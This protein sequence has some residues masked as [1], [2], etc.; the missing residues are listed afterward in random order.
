MDLT[1]FNNVLY[2][3]S[4]F[5]T[6]GAK[7]HAIA[8]KIT[9]KQTALVDCRNSLFLGQGAVRMI[10]IPL[11]DD[12]F[13]I[14]NAIKIG[15]NLAIVMEPSHISLC[16]TGNFKKFLRNNQCQVVFIRSKKEHKPNRQIL[17]YE[18]EN[19]LV[20][21]RE[22]ESCWITFREHFL[23]GWFIRVFTKHKVQEQR[24]FKVSGILDKALEYFGN[25]L[26]KDFD[27]LGLAQLFFADLIFF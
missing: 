24:K 25:S 9:G 26:L 8:R 3:N 21:V 6:P 5:D 12:G 7:A 19:A 2:H 16:S 15:V 1:F 14:A 11:A 10:H 27:V 13:G 22:I 20:H 18:L 4:G 23:K 17:F